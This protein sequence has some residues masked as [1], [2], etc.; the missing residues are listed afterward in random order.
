MRKKM[1]KRNLYLYPVGETHMKLYY[2]GR[3]LDW[4]GLPTDAGLFS[5]L[6]QRGIMMIYSLLEGRLPQLESI[7]LNGVCF[8]GRAHP[9]CAFDL[10][11]EGPHEGFYLPAKTASALFQEA[12]IPYFHIPLED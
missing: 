2:N 5:P 4:E 12:G 6:Y 1:K 11:V 9:F 10:W 8:Q 7:C 3:E